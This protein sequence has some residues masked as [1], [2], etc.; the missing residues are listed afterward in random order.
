[1]SKRDYYE[2]LGVAKTASEDELKKAFRRLAMK[3]H[4]DRN[5]DDPQAQEHFKEAKEAYEILSDAQQRAIYDRHGHAGLA[6]GMGGRECWRGKGSGEGESSE[7]ASPHGLCL[8]ANGA[9]GQGKARRRE[10]PNH[11]CVRASDGARR[12][13]CG[14]PHPASAVRRSL[15]SRNK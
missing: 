8:P 3:L 2:T 12:A 13:R 5:P 1:M 9:G 15:S 6:G 14:L 10:S 7:R 4:P 11:V